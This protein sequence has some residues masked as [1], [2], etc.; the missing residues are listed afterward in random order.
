MAAF[1]TRT[2]VLDELDEA[3]AA[4]DRL[5]TVMGDAWLERPIPLRHPF[6]FYLGHLP[7]FAWNQIARGVLGRKGFRPAFDDLFERGIDPLDDAEAERVAIHDWPAVQEV[8]EYR[9]R[10][11]DE[12]R[13]CVDDVAERSDENVLASGLRAYHL[14]LE[15]EL[16]HHETLFYMLH[17]LEHR[18][19]VRPEEP[20]EIVPCEMRLPERVEVPAGRVTLGTRFERVPFGWDNEFPERTADVEAFSIDRTP[21]TIGAYRRFVDAG[22][23]DEKRWWTAPDWVWLKK[24]RRTAPQQWGLHEGLWMRR[25]FFGWAPLDQVAGWPVMVTGAEA[26]AYCRWRRGRLPTE[27]ELHRAAYGTPDG[28]EQPYPWG[29]AAPTARHGN[30]D[31]ANF[32]PMPVGH[33][34][35]GRSAFGV[36]ELVGNGWEWTSTDFAPYEGFEAWIPSY[37]GYSQDFFSGQHAVV[38]GASWATPARLLRPSFRNWFQRQ[39]PY[40]MATF[41]CA[42]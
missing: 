13:D 3:W 38:F 10:V 7:A 37:P 32:D 16:M 41:R 42:W 31:L 34:P 22:G 39:Y 6:L 40:V 4:T 36:D 15:H 5:F 35:L 12:L 23:Y 11:R 28:E 27:E 17:E 24:H 19:K 21:V 9:D 26:R 8:V 25:T 1:Q 18:R 2:A 30:F 33:Y 29:D 20:P 14:V